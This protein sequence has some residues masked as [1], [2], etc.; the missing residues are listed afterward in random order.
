[1][2]GVPINRYN[3]PLSKLFPFK[4]PIS[5]TG[6]SINRDPLKLCTSSHIVNEYTKDN[7]HVVE[8]GLMFDNHYL[9]PVLLNGVHGVLFIPG[10]REPIPGVPGQ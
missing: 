6:L 8:I 9:L 10:C 2:T 7:L 4:R 1:M 3:F 5:V